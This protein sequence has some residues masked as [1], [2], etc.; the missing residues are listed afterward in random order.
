VVAA[1]ALLGLWRLAKNAE[2]PTGAAIAPWYDVE[3]RAHTLRFWQPMVV[4]GIL[5]TKRYAHEMYRVGGF[6]D[7]RA[8]DAVDGRMRRQLILAQDDAPTVVVVL[9]H[10]VLDR[11]I[12]SAEVMAEQCTKL[13]EL[14]ESVLLHVLPSSPGA[15]AGL[16]GSIS[17]ASVP[18]ELDTLLTG[19]L[20]EDRVTVEAAQVRAASATFERVRAVS[21][22][23]VE[24]AD[25]VREAQERWTA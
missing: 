3:G 18:G 9:D 11:C 24:T 6:T 21:R 5:Q 23:I 7:E 20:L 8:R 15:N 1:A 12:G 19:G 2:D 13:L 22:N 16:G 25:I 17:L 10:M 4:P 14:P